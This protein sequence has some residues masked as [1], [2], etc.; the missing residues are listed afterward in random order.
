MPGVTMLDTWNAVGQILVRLDGV[1]Y[2]GRSQ[3]LGLYDVRYRGE[4]LLIVTRARVMQGP[5]DGMV[6]EVDALQQDGKPSDSAAGTELLHLLRQR[7]PEE[8][9]WIEAGG[10]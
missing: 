10:R 8:L 3:M 4:P 7:L 9:A 1:T 2:Q 5:A 6:T